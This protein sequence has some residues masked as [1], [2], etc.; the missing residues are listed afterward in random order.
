MITRERGA[1]QALARIVREALAQLVERAGVA[2]ET[3]KMGSFCHFARVRMEH[4]GTSGRFW[5]IGEIPGT[6]LHYA[7]RRGAVNCATE[8][9]PGIF[10]PARIG[11]VSHAAPIGCTR[12]HG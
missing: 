12:L 6:S 9:A 5:N 11:F 3:W 2:S 1:G 8:A 10:G 7:P 4:C